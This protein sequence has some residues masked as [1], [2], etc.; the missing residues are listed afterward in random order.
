MEGLNPNDIVKAIHI[1][2]L[3]DSTKLDNLCG[4]RF[5]D[6]CTLEFRNIISTEKVMVDGKEKNVTTLK[7]IATAVAEWK[8]QNGGSAGSET[9]GNTGGDTGGSGGNTG[10]SGGDTG[11]S[12][13]DDGDDEDMN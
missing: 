8:A 5:K 12:G 10:G 4:P 6:A 2:F 3:P 13:G 1:R 7:P 9:G 11:G